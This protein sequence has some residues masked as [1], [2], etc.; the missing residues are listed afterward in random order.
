ME[1]LHSIQ[2]YSTVGHWTLIAGSLNEAV[3]TAYM[4]FSFSGV[5]KVKVFEGGPN[6][7]K[8]IDC[9]GGELV[10]LIV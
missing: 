5:H 4:L 7:P 9:S 3:T 6:V 8:A 2:I 10:Y 1:K